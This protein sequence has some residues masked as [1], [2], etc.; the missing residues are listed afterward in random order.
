MIAWQLPLHLRQTACLVCPYW[1]RRRCAGPNNRESLEEWGAEA[2]GC[3]DPQK[4]IAFYEDLHVGWTGLGRQ[5]TRPVP[6]L[7]SFIPILPRGLPRDTELSSE[8]TYGISWSNLLN[9][10]GSFKYATSRSLRK[11]L[12]L[13]SDMKLCLVGTAMDKRIERLW[14][15]SDTKQSWKRL[16]DLEL[17]FVTSLTFSV[18]DEHPRFDQIFNQERNFYTHDVFSSL[19]LRSIPFVFHVTTE[20]RR[21]ATEWLL[22]HQEITAIAWSAQMYRTPRDFDQFVSNNQLLADELRML[23]RQVRLFIVGCAT[24]PKLKRLFGA[25]GDFPITLASGKPAQRA[26]AGERTLPDLRHE[27]ASRETPR[28]LLVSQNIE[29][30]RRVIEE[31]A[32]TVA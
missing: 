8:M 23:G 25:F 22:E 19:Q 3:L 13:E 29:L 6:D 15:F 10:D 27:K 17:D 4:Q 7:A 20:D 9:R 16:L 31:L 21:E 26:N 1:N 30:Y 24:I 2:I 11:S 18:W 12:R 32:T 14:E 28:A 5:Q